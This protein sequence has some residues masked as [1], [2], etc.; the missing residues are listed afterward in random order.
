MI[1]DDI[2]SLWKH[3]HPFMR[4]PQPM[5]PRDIEQVILSLIAIAADVRQLE[6]SALSDVAKAGNDL[7]DNV[8]RLP[9]WRSTPPRAAA[10]DEGGAA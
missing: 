7:P 1:S 2:D 8:L 3:L 10:S 9:L 4:A 5:T 6:Q